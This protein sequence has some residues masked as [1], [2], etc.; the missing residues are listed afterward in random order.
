[1]GASC[2]CLENLVI[3][4][5]RQ[6]YKRRHI[7]NSNQQKLFKPAATQLC[8]S[9]AFSVCAHWMLLINCFYE[10]TTCCLLP[11]CFYWWI[12]MELSYVF[13]NVWTATLFENLSWNPAL[14][15]C[16]YIKKYFLV[17]FKILCGTTVLPDCPQSMVRNLQIL[18]LVKFGHIQLSANLNK[19]RKLA[20]K[21]HMNKSIRLII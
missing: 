21:L 3:E 16:W 15:S 2:A 13:A 12:L 19:K 4:N 10:H 14:P 8:M 1:M 11:E 5:Q 6:N 18:P 20:S 9:A 7:E 17:L